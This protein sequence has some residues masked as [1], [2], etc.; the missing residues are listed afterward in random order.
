MEVVHKNY[1]DMSPP[2]GAFVHAVRANG[3]LFLS[4]FT[5]GNSPAEQGDMAAQ[6]EATIDRIEQVLKAEGGSLDDVVK[7]TVYVT[8]I[9]KTIGREY[10]QMEVIDQLFSAPYRS[11][12]IDPSQSDNQ[13][14]GLGVD[15][16][17]SVLRQGSKPHEPEARRTTHAGH[18]YLRRNRCH[19]IRRTCDGYPHR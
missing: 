6:T 18:H 16:Y 14:L 5:A 4:G 15:D 19:S 1:P 10:G 7:V 2:G 8:E 12:F 13:T 3:L 17:G 11:R 9:D